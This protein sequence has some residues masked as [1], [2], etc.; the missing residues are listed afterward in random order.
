MS[1]MGSNQYRLE[2]VQGQFQLQNQNGEAVGYV[3][4]VTTES[5]STYYLRDPDHLRDPN[6]ID[7][8]SALDTPQLFTAKGSLW[9]TGQLIIHSNKVDV[10]TSPIRSL[11]IQNKNGEPFE[12]LANTVVSAPELVSLQTSKKNFVLV[13]GEQALEIFRD[14]AKIDDEYERQMIVRRDGINVDPRYLRWSDFK[15]L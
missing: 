11:H 6:D 8:P 3:K 14:Q 1:K 7:N 4:S 12:I 2:N 9:A 15:V 13:E 10:L 5:G